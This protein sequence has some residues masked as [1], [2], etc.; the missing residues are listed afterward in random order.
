[1]KVVLGINFR[2]LWKR[3]DVNIVHRTPVDSELTEISI[4]LKHCVHD[5]RRRRRDV[6]WGIK[7][8]VTLIPMILGAF[9]LVDSKECFGKYGDLSI[10]SGISQ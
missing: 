10:C 8:F 2:L 3:L 6:L 4:L 5:S 9:L 7:T 1:M